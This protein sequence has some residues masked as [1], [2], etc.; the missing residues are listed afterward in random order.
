MEYI[1][2]TYGEVKI[3]MSERMESKA[4]MDNTSHWQQSDTFTTE[5]KRKNGYRGNNR[6][7]ITEEKRRN[8][9]SL[10]QMAWIFSV[11]R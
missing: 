7:E 9:V 6:R 3:R 1:N 10:N 4:Q 2:I 5:T 8:I 11:K